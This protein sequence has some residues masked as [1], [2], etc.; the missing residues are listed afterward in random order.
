MKK[1]I[2]GRRYDTEKAEEIA[3]FNNG[4]SYSDFRYCSET[5]Y[6]TKRGRWFLVG[7]GGAMSRWAQR[8]GDGSRSG[9]DGL[10]YFE[11]NEAKDWLE[12]HDEQDQLERF[13]SDEIKDA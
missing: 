10:Q 7:I 6:R 12:Y 4:L 9:G 13:F 5:L 11:P 3:E 1:I 8:H 2:K